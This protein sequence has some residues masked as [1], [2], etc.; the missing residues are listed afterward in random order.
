MVRSDT[1]VFLPIAGQFLRP[2]AIRRSRTYAISVI[3]DELCGPFTAPVKAEDGPA[4]KDYPSGVPRKGKRELGRDLRGVVAKN[5]RRLMDGSEDLQTATALG[6]ASK[7]GRRT[8]DRA[9][10]QST[11]ANLDTIQALC[12]ALNCQPWE[13]VTDA[14]AQGILGKVFGKPVRDSRLGTAWTRPDKPLLDSRQKA[15]ETLPSR[16]TKIKSRR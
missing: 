6:K 10:D 16:S 1:L 5:L 4:G 3:A 9:L 11:A 7:L 8:V 13:L 14:D 12:T 2:A 15:T